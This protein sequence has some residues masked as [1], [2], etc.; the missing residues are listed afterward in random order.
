MTQGSKVVWLPQT[1]KVTYN[2]EVVR[3]HL[4]NA[5]IFPNLSTNANLNDWFM[6]QMPFI[7]N[8]MPSGP[9]YSSKEIVQGAVSRSLGRI[10]ED[11]FIPWMLHPRDKRDTFEPDM[12]D[13]KVWV[14]SLVITQTGQDSAQT[15]R[16]Q[17]G[18]VNESYNLTL[19]ETGEATIQAVS[20]LGI[21]QGLQTFNQLFYRHSSGP[22]WYSPV[23]PVVVED[24]PEYPHRGLLLDVSRHWYPVEDILRTIDALA[25][26][27]M[28]RLHIHATDSQAWPLD[29][30]SLP[31]V[32]RKGAY[33]HHQ[34]YSAADQKAIMEH[35]TCQG[36]QVIIEIDMPGHIG[37]L[38]E[39]HPELV[40]A[41][42]ERPYYWYC[43]QPP[44]GALKLNDSSVDSFLKALFNDI[45]PRVSPYTSYFHIGGDEL[46]ANDSTLDPGIGTNDEDVLKPLLQKFI[47]TQH[48]RVFDAGLNPLVWEEIP[49]E[50]DIEL[51]SEVVIQSW[52]G[53]VS[54]ITALGHKVVDSN[55]NFWVR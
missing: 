30:P 35:G 45:L 21:L 39:S 51:Q 41:Y 8:Y 12:Y 40:V 14:N 15:F 33:H 6:G 1:V 2:G 42:D 55:Y 47:D 31:E 50:W 7:S 34:I 9:D 46:N 3:W 22:F 37:A 49:L 13:K 20:A 29:I 36:V 23:A 52:K 32:A 53:T 24:Y 18:E 4:P 5:E 28:N 10:F 48:Q 17:A 11:Y 19:S 44:C 16:A 38:G 25:W 43:A 26:N 54:N 27:K